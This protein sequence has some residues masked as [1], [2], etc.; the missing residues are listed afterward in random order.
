L[1]VVI[2]C[3]FSVLSVKA[4]LNFL[5]L[6]NPE[7]PLDKPATTLKP[8]AIFF[9]SVLVNSFGLLIAFYNEL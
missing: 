6:A 4:G 2:I 3:C 1:E 8:Y 7:A 9:Q 5:L